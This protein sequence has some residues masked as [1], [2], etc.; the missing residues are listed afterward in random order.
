M[1]FWFNMVYNK[2]KTHNI[3][4]RMRWNQENYI[5][6]EISWVSEFVS[7]NYFKLFCFI[8]LQ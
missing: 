8:E 7:K 4:F 2:N 3:F 6:L 1:Q 5:Q